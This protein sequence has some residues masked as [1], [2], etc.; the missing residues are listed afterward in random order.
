MAAYK[1]K[2]KIGEKEIA[3]EFG[4]KAEA[5]QYGREWLLDYTDEDVTAVVED[6]RGET[7]ASGTVGAGQMWRTV[8]VWA[9]SGRIVVEGWDTEQEARRSAESVPPYCPED[10][11]VCAAMVLSAEVE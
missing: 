3:E 5:V 10:P 4:R 8:L 9:P 1:A 7:V 11:E 2:V 6:E